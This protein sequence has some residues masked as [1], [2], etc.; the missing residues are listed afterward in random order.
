MKLKYVGA[1]VMTGEILTKLCTDYN[2]K[3][4]FAIKNVFLVA[5]RAGKYFSVG[6]NDHAPSRK[7][8]TAE[9]ICV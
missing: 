8:G 9:N 1:I 5:D 4:T 6:S 3:I 7:L 2:V